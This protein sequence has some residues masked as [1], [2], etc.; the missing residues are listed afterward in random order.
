[1]KAG[2]GKNKGS[3]FEREI[4]RRISLWLS[5]GER[6]DLICRTVL[7]G[8]QFTVGTGPNAGDLMAQH[9]MAFRFFELFVLE[10]KHWKNI[11]MIRFLVKDGELYKA[12]VKVRK[13]AAKKQKHWLLVARQN[14]Q[15]TLIFMPVSAVYL[16]RFNDAPISNSHI[17]FNGTVF[18]S[19]FDEFLSTALPEQLNEQSSNSGSPSNG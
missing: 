11:E 16:F 8:G 19:Y 1:M 14:F 6:K 17:L 9:P 12:L 10:C 13:E 7:S 5:K 3:D 15:S 2:Q 18:M 4:G